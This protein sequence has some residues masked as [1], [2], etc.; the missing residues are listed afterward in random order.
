MMDSFLSLS[1]LLLILSKCNQAQ[2]IDYIKIK[3]LHKCD[4]GNIF[5]FDG[6]FNL[7]QLCQ[8]SC[9]VCLYGE[10]LLYE[11]N[12]KILCVS[13]ECVMI[14]EVVN[15][16]ISSQ[17]SSDIM[18]Q[19]QNGQ[20]ICGDNKISGD[21]QCEDGNDIPFDGCF[22]CRY[23]CEELCLI[24]IKGYC[25][26]KD[27]RNYKSELFNIQFN[28]TYEPSIINS[29]DDDKIPQILK[30]KNFVNNICIFCIEGYYLNSVTNQCKTH[31]GDYIVQGKEE[32]DDGNQENHDGCSQCKLIKYNQCNQEG[33]NFCS[34]CEYGK[35]LKCIDGYLLQNYICT[36]QC[37]D[38]Q[39]NAIE[40]EEC[41]NP[42]DKG[43]IHCKIHPSYICVG[44]TFSLCLT[45]EIN[46][47]QCQSLDYSL[48]CQKCIDGYYPIG[49][50]CRPCDD[51]CVSCQGQSFLCTSCYRKDC[52]FC[53]NYEG[54]YTDVENKVCITICGDGILIKQFEE[55]DDGNLL[56]EDGC[57]SNC[58]L[59]GNK[60]DY[61]NLQI[62]KSIKPYQYQFQMGNEQN[63][64]TLDCYNANIKI[65]SY[66]SNQFQYTIESQEDLCIIQF[67][68]FSTIYSYN[69]IHVI[70][71]FY[72]TKSRS[73]QQQENTIQFDIKPEE[74]IVKSDNQLQQANSIS[75]AQESFGF[76]FLILIPISIITNLFD[77]LWA[78]L[79]ILSWINN[80]YFLN[81]N[82]PFNVETFLLNSDWS[83]F[84]NFP[85][86]QG[87]NQPDCDYYFKAPLRFQYKGI[88]PLFFN[89]VQ[90]PLM[91]IFSSIVVY[92]LITFLLKILRLK[93]QTQIEQKIIQ[94]KKKFSIF[95]LNDNTQTQK[96]KNQEKIKSNK[97][98]NFRN[99]KILDSLINL[100]CLVQKELKKKIKQ[101]VSLCFLDITLAIML[102]LNN[103]Q[104]LNNF[105]VAIN[106]IIAFFSISLI[107]YYLYECFQTINI[108]KHLAENQ[109]FKEKY[110]IYYENVNTNSSYG[111]KYK[112]VGL[113][114]K[115]FYIFF[116]VYCYDTPLLQTLCCFLSS[117]LGLALILYENPYQTK[118]QFIFQFFSDLSLSSIL[119]IIVLFA[120]ND[121]RQV[122]FIEDKKI[123][124]GWIIIAFVILAL[125]VEIIV[126]FFQLILSFYSAFKLMKSLIMSIFKKKEENQ[127]KIEQF[128]DRLENNQVPQQE[129]QEQQSEQQQE[130]SE[131]QSEQQEQEQELQDQMK[132]NINKSE[133][134]NQQSEK[135]LDEMKLTKLKSQTIQLTLEKQ[136]L[137]NICTMNDSH[138]QY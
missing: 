5:T 89:N 23:Q 44:P 117:N 9:Q 46:C 86:Y 128:Q 17:K 29:S 97:K 14:Q 51:N 90:I 6:C 115:I 8:E 28:I 43:C 18:F 83:N 84:F 125:S 26:Q 50:Q 103:A 131:Q 55:C 77:Y 32:C 110:Y 12:E 76:I 87:L 38:G 65:D 10:C 106:Q 100:L 2:T 92:L 116:M 71:Y 111:Y 113:L 75:N 45:C 22:N 56:D 67:T 59:E 81:V 109:F 34:V 135:N 53:E 24:C 68:F 123:I 52:D 137:N 41:D 80:F 49:K 39:V 93:N 95:K 127:N 54:F 64:Y 48:T 124:L 37:G 88:N 72:E 78:V 119:F 70:F 107:L 25:I 121:Q 99:H 122:S 105:V 79:E 134:P 104:H 102:Q 62:L 133:I 20:P 112:F 7:Q 35:C 4:D 138:I 66:N 11:E 130:Q 118:F 108:H 85:T 1:L 21:E 16:L 31:C 58:H 27:T 30:C 15:P 47:I 132:F 136:T 42:D 61:S 19:N 63:K 129:Q 33:Q 57:D 101:T 36:T 69:V 74:F 98:K 114:R 96:L 40:N 60:I 126:L 120:F 91:F 73:L 13:G 3:F 94:S 82:Y